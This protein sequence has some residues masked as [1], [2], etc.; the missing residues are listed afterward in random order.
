MSTS[1]ETTI[2]Q[3]R[4]LLKQVGSGTHT[5]KSLSRQESAIAT[6]L[7]LREQATPAQIG[8]FMI[9][10]RIKRPTPT[11]L[12]GMLDTYDKLGPK[13]TEIE[14]A[15]PVTV[16]CNPYDGR[17]RTAP[18]TPLTA[19]ILAAADCP[20]VVPGGDRMPTKMGLPTADIWQAL[21]LEITQ[22]SLTQAQQ[23][24]AS[25][26]LGFIY[27]PTHFPLAEAMVPYRQQ[28][29]KRPTLATIEIMWSPY[30]GKSNLVSGYVHPPTEERTQATFTQRSTPFFTTVKGLEG[31]CDMSRARTAILGLSELKEGELHT[32]R[33]L[34][35]PRDYGFDGADLEFLP[36]DE[37]I[38]QYWAVLE[39]KE[40]E[41]GHSAIWNSG[42]YLWR[43]G[44]VKSL[45]DG[46]ELGR[47][48]LATGAVKAKLQ[49]IKSA[50]YMM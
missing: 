47:S 17:S 40:N 25:T 27:Q 11:E 36:L 16:F 1:S 2:E 41:I 30:A 22:L 24:L 29:G 46:F 39:G 10:Q 49:S 32:E 9:A 44:R 43:V 48:L 4:D 18:I 5:S 38:E 28:I 13:L 42:F 26:G 33:L 31:S 15:Y 45:E 7:M 12:A 20:V 50:I 34:L 14:S 3:F 19:L 35:H 6:E 37:L 21:G 23:I 8:A